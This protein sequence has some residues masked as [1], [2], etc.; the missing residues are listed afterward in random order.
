MAVVPE[1]KKSAMPVFEFSYF[2]PVGEK[3]VT[4]KSDAAPLSVD[5]S[6]PPAPPPPPKPVTANV[7]NAEPPS[8]STPSSKPND[9]LGQRYDLDAARSYTPLYAQKPFW[10]VQGGLAAALVLLLGLRLHRGPDVAAR[11]AAGLRREKST[12]MARLRNTGLSHAEFLDTAARVAQIET[13]L[14]TG[15]NAS[16]IDAGTVRAAGAMSEQTG[17]V[18]DEIF[19]SRAELLYAGGGQGDGSVSPIE[20]ERVL[21]ALRE[22]EKNHVR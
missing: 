21:E 7:A 11:E 18:I 1:K 20:R 6:A 5:G 14:A 22:L 12:A 10:Y 2:D 4:L 8:A 3:Y 19:S 9:I 15:L 13:A 17:A 16:S